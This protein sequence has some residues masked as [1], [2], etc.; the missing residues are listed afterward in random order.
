MVTEASSSASRNQLPDALKNQIIDYLS[1][2]FRTEGY[3]KQRLFDSLPTGLR[4][5]ILQ[6][7]FLPI[8][9]KT[10]LFQGVSC[11]FLLHLVSEIQ[12]GYFPARHDIILQEGAPTDLYIVVSGAVELVFNKGGLDKKLVKEETGDMFGELGVLFNK[13]HEFRATT[14]ML[15]QL[16]ILGRSALLEVLES[17]VE[18]RQIVMANLSQIRL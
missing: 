15:S 17:H 18:D 10:Y 6:Y 8:L 14:K 16:L 3:Q 1:L 11:S 5:N 9:E 13:P 4:L 7:L 2:K 12:A